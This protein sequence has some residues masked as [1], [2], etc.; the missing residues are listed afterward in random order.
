MYFALDQPAFDLKDG[1]T[2]N[3]EIVLDERLGV[4]H[5]PA[6]AVSA[7]NGQPIVY[8]LRDDGMKA[9]KYVETGATIDARTE[10][11]SGLEEG[12]SVIIK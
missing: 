10:I 8:Y 11:L 7:A 12:E 3:L 1:D 6:K 5:V 9:Y 4:L 2:G